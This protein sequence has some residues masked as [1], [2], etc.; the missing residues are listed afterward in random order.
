VSL[1]RSFAGRIILLAL[2]VFGLFI[3]P[4]LMGVRAAQV[5]VPGVKAG[6]TAV[7]AQTVGRWNLP[8]PPQPPFS[9]FINLN[10]T[11]LTVTGVTSSNVTAD[12]AFTY[13][14]KTTTRDTILG[15]VMTD[16]GNITFWFTA[17]N[18]TAGTPIYTTSGA[19]IINSTMVI[20]FAGA[21]RAINIYN[22][23]ISFPGGTEFVN[24]WW[25][26]ITGLLVHVDFAIK[27]PTANAF[28]GA[29]LVQTNAWSPTPNFGIGL[30]AVPNPLLIAQ[31]FSNAS[32]LHLL[33]ERGFSGNVTIDALIPGCST[34]CLKL[35][36]NPSIL[37]LKS[38]GS[39]LSVLNVTTAPG[40]APGSYG[41]LVT[42]RG[43]SPG[44]VTVNST[45][46]D[47]NVVGL[48][49]DEF[50]TAQINFF[51]SNPAPGQP[52]LADGEGGGQPGQAD[53]RPRVLR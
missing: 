7:Y 38:G 19:P 2:I 29:Q 53:E 4:G 34:S 11:T 15:S 26:K 23:T 27:T 17:A 42:A 5:Y 13:V 52:G 41:V 28:A 20:I 36:V 32:I 35:T 24:A 14:N 37:F 16:A 22:A 46:V 18:L 44:L 9:Q 25:D 39:G 33:S 30:F 6:T 45:L 21:P 10:F 50:P 31:G 3:A 47:V 43:L 49:P 1:L 12:Q 40:T 48:G 51:P 8:G